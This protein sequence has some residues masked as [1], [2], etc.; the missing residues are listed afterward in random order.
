MTKTRDL[1]VIAMLG[2]ASMVLMATIQVPILPTA[3]YLR[4]DPSDAIGLTVALLIGPAAGVAV[5]AL[6]DLLYLIF[7]ARS[8]FGPLGNFIAVATFVAVAGWIYQRLQL[9]WT[10]RL[11]G[12]LGMGTLARVVI[13]IPANFVLLALQFGMTPAKVVTLLWPVI[14]PFNALVSVI[15]AALTFM[16]IG[17]LARGR[18]LRV[19]ARTGGTHDS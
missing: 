15:N 12:A 10:A 18:S 6:K 17:A 1:L 5:V 2:G 8:I 14:I 16:I 9:P 7:R 3:P 13:M 11:V 19:E 4:Y